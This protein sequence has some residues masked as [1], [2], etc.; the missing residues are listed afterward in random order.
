MRFPM[1]ICSGKKRFFRE[2]VK[3]G[4]Q[5]RQVV[6]TRTD[7][8][9]SFY[10]G[11]TTPRIKARILWLQCCLNGWDAAVKFKFLFTG[12]KKGCCWI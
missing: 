1:A 2:K 10:T 4:F 11:G 9:I 12:G 3:R 5:K 8:N 7:A 6:Y